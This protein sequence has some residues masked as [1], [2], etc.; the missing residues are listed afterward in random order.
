MEH[1]E[2]FVDSQGFP[3][4]G[5]RLYLVRAGTDEYEPAYMDSSYTIPCCNPIILD[6]DGKTVFYT[7][8]P[9]AFTVHD[10]NGNPAH[11][12][13]DDRPYHRNTIVRS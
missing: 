10:F 9:V 5:G 2:Q 8:N 4:S 11:L 1:R 6:M 7:L 12:Q 3:L 13:A